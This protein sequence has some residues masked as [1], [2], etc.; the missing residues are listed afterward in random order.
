MKKV[1]LTSLPVSEEIADQMLTNAY[2]CDRT[3]YFTND[4]TVHGSHLH[5][6]KKEAPNPQKFT[7]KKYQVTVT[8]HQFDENILNKII[9]TY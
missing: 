4:G 8:S 2:E 1:T 5:A 7:I 3:S 6:E 9:E